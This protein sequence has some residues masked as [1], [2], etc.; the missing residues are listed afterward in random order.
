MATPVLAVL[1]KACQVNG[2]TITCDTYVGGIRT[3]TAERDGFEVTAHFSRPR[4]E[5]GRVILTANI[6]H[7]GHVKQEAAGSNKRET[8][9]G[10]L[11]DPSRVTAPKCDD[12][13]QLKLAQ[14]MDPVAFDPR[15]VPENLG[16]S[17]DQVERQQTALLY[18]KR[19]LDSGW[20]PS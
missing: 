10:W 6:R 12:P 13:E 19:V 15:A 8:V 3:F 5:S 14:I 17:W 2:W 7:S 11:N 1:R 18:A 4:N 9:L 20:T 16:Q